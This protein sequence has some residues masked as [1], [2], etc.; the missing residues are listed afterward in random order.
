M[1]NRR[2]NN[3]E[4]NDD[5]IHNKS[6]PNKEQD[7]CS[8]NHSTTI[9]VNPPHL[10][11]KLFVDFVNFKYPRLKFFLVFVLD[12]WILNRKGLRND[13]SSIEKQEEA[14]QECNLKHNDDDVLILEGIK[15]FFSCTN[16]S[17]VQS[18]CQALSMR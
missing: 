2:E 4:V 17:R 11:R 5:D 14:E 6:S 9:T 15:E 13:I 8:T 3:N 12:Y 16:P 18:V 10:L 1:N 7:H